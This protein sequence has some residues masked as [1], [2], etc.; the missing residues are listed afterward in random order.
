MTI[1]GTP[2]GTPLNTSF[3]QGTA[4]GNAVQAA[5]QVVQPGVGM[6]PPGSNNNSGTA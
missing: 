6:F 2:G 5:L 4:P 3:F 1:F